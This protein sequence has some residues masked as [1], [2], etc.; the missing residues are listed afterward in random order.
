[1][2]I[3]AEAECAAI[4]T[5]AAV[6]QEEHTLE[7]EQGH[8]HQQREEIR[9]RGEMLEMK[10]ELEPKQQKMTTSEMLKLFVHGNGTAKE[11]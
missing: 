2:H 9:K 7:K 6:L 1:M 5:K 4:L 11:I 3:N 10:T 8:L